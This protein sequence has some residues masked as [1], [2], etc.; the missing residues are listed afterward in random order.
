VVRRGEPAFATLDLG[1]NNCRYL[2]DMGDA[3][4]AA[5]LCIGA[6]QADLVIHGCAI[7]DTICHLWPAQRLRVVDRGL[8]EEILLGLM[9]EHTDNQSDGIAVATGQAA[10][11]T[12][13]QFVDQSA[14]PD[15]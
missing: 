12:A 6:L 4:S 8:R 1:T 2:A 5:H 7:L 14:G 11:W 9:D 10:D 13:D 15:A 3:T